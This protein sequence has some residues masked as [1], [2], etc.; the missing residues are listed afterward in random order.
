V[1]REGL[2]LMFLKTAT[3]RGDIN[4]ISPFINLIL[5]VILIKLTGLV[6]KVMKGLLLT[7]EG[8]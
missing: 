4:K 2:I 5:K 6:R 3:V 8:T 1:K 7:K